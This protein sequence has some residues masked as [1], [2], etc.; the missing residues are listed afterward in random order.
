MGARDCSGGEIGARA[1]GSGAAV[2]SGQCSKVSGAGY[3]LWAK[4][5][6]GEEEDLA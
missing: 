1:T 2:R 3:C 6:R 5:T 4:K